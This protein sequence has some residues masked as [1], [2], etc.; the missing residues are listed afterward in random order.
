METRLVSKN[1]K[2]AMTVPAHPSLD[3]NK[4][5][6]KNNSSEIDLLH[7][8]SIGNSI[9]SN[10]EGGRSS[11][12]AQPTQTMTGNNND[13]SPSLVVLYLKILE[14]KMICCALLK[15]LPLHQGN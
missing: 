13:I 8:S 5:A 7:P 14:S 1:K 11:T 15:L 12:T 2:K 6:R 4:K 3:T 10:L 9:L